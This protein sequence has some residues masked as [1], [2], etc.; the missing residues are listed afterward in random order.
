MEFACRP[1]I[2]DAIKA[3][4]DKRIF[5][6][7]MMFDDAYYKALNRHSHRGSTGQDP[8]RSQRGQRLF[9]RTEVTVA[10]YLA[11]ALPGI[12]DAFY[13]PAQCAALVY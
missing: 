3:R 7:T 8:F 2:C 6:Y 10:A 12:R 9:L 11:A 5:G 13:Q 4:V 1:A